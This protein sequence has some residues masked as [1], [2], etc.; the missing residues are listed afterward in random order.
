MYFF[1]EPY[2]LLVRVIF[3]ELF[4]LTASFCL[5]CPRN[6]AGITKLLI[7]GIQL[8]LLIFEKA[9]SGKNILAIFVEEL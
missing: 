6:S 5:S 4:C 1:H 9:D 8:I 2:L 7:N 3:I